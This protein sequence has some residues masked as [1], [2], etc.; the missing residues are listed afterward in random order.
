MGVKVIKIVWVS[1]IFVLASNTVLAST[2]RYTLSSLPEIHH[3]GKRSV[4]RKLIVNDHNVNDNFKTL[5]RS[6]KHRTKR[7]YNFISVNTVALLPFVTL[8]CISVVSTEVSP[9]YSNNL[10]GIFIPPRSAF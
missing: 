2:A 9:A 6:V 4:S 8:N 5:F 3:T 7:F 1:L 10:S